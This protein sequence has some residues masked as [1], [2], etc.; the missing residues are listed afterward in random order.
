MTKSK[1]LISMLLAFVMLIT[2]CSLSF[3]AFAADSDI[4]EANSLAETA[5]AGMNANTVQA[6]DTALLNKL[7]SLSASERLRVNPTYYAYAVHVAANQIIRSENGNKTPTAAQRQAKYDGIAASN[8]VILNQFDAVL[9]IPDEYIKVIKDIHDVNESIKTDSVLTSATI[10][11]VY[12]NNFNNLNFGT[13]ETAKLMFEAFW[14]SY[15]YYSDEQLLFAE[16]LVL[17]NANNVTN[18]FGTTQKNHI[19]N[20][21]VT[22][23]DTTFSYYFGDRTAKRLALLYYVYTA[24]PVNV[25]VVKAKYIASNKWI[26]SE[27]GPTEYYNELKEFYTNGNAKTKKFFVD[28]LTALSDASDDFAGLE[29]LG[30]T[31]DVGLDLL[32]GKDVAFADIKE[33]YNAYNDLTDTGKYI[34]DLFDKNFTTSP[35]PLFNPEISNLTAKENIKFGD[36][37]AA[38]SIEYLAANPSTMS[39]AAGYNGI[40]LQ[41]LINAVADAYAEQLPI[42]EYTELVNNTIAKQP[43]ITQDDVDA[44]WDAFNNLK[45]EHQNIVKNTSELWENTQTIMTSQF[46][47]YVNAVDMNNVTDANRTEST[48]L[49][50][51]T[52]EN[53]K[54]L[55]VPGDDQIYKSEYNKYLQ[56]QI[57]DFRKYVEGVDLNNITAENRTVAEQKYNALTDE[58][59]AAVQ[60]DADLYNTYLVILASE[61]K[62]YVKSIDLDKVDDSVRKEARER[63]LALSDAAKENAYCDPET[64][65]KYTQIQAP[66]VD[67][68]KHSEEAA[69]KADKVT[70]PNSDSEAIKALGKEKSIDN[71]ENFIIDDLLP[72]LTDQ[73]VIEDKNDVVNSALKQH[74]SNETIGK[75]Y[76]LYATLSHNKSE[77]APGMKAGDVVQSVI[78]VE[79]FVARLYEDDFAAAKGKI[80][81]V[82]ASGKVPTDKDGNPVQVPCGT[83]DDGTTNYEDANMYDAIAA[84]EFKN[85][86]FGFNDGDRDGFEKALLAVLRP[87]T[88]LCYPDNPFGIEF[89]N[90]ADKATGE[91]TFGVYECCV[92]LLEVLGVKNL[93]TDAEYKANYLTVFAQTYATAPESSDYEKQIRATSIAGDELLKPVIDGVFSLIDD[94]FN[95]LTDILILLPRLGD[96]VQSDIP[97]IAYSNLV[98]D[99]GMLSGLVTDIEIE[100]MKLDTLVNKNVLAPALL[101]LINDKLA[102][103][104][105][106]LAMPDWNALNKYTTF[107]VNKSAQYDKDYVA[108]R[109]IGGDDMF[110]EAVYY[111]YDN[112]FANKANADALKEKIGGFPLVGS[113]LSAL[114]EKGEKAGKMKTYAAI[115]DYFYDNGDNKDAT[116][117]AGKSIGDAIKS[118]NNTLNLNKIDA[119][120]AKIKLS[121]RKYA[122]NGKIQK[123][124]VK[125]TLNGEVLKK[126]VAYKV[127]YS[128]DN[129]KKIGA[130]K[131]TVVFIGAYEGKNK[132]AKYTIGPKN[133]RKIKLVSKK[134]ALK[135]KYKKSKSTSVKG[136]YIEYSTSKAFKNS[137]KVKVEGR[138][139]TSKTISGLKSGKKYYVRIKSYTVKSGK[140]IYSPFSN[141]KAVKVK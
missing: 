135:I 13:N 109:Y 42:E 65:N 62:D 26:D 76:G 92:K 51:D 66:D 60:D 80:Y 121:K 108:V 83:N 67:T 140:K 20:D 75:I 43:N 74:L 17:A 94:E 84:I 79:G 139:T 125:V 49:L 116:A 40:K 141:P 70:Y 33:A 6:N 85:G 72:T 19:L 127:K 1:K 110:T 118:L 27:N 71:V 104:G 73:I 37:D 47:N 25:N 10:K 78:P 36:D 54:P 99:L 9:K 100:G 97:S 134:G 23:G 88:G 113:N 119:S 64:W 133:A 122:Y 63:Y 58:F 55:I 90:H 123:P 106:N 32:D 117:D 132:T 8:D 103:L 77:I 95:T 93:P 81:N 61:F 29:K 15:K 86:D 102:G 41:A 46:V 69:K 16:I 57:D 68:N 50:N 21:S 115:L 14:D 30:K 4:A 39:N 131:V 44:V 24:E 136:Y 38:A 120:K 7:N 18:A 5:I 89:F 53:F 96:L 12:D 2:S 11:M 138:S 22:F 56:I 48:K 107:K 98:R 128:K 124:S 34:I 111:L 3:F 35:A 52:D 105:I 112:L 87:I 137:K 126:G 129:S 82:I 114:I 31:I 45:E 59:K 130:Y 101:K 28:Y 91:Y